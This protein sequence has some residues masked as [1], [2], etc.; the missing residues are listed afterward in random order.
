MQIAAIIRY[1]SFP[2]SQVGETKVGRNAKS[3]RH[4]MINLR[5]HPRYHAPSI[6][7]YVSV[8][9]VYTIDRDITLCVRAVGSSTSEEYNKGLNSF[10]RGNPVDVVIRIPLLSRNLVSVGIY[11]TSPALT[12]PYQERIQ[13]E[14]GESPTALRICQKH[15]ESMTERVN[16]PE[17]PS[18]EQQ[19]E[20]NCQYSSYKCY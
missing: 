12:E 8:S 6:R 7:K 2:F 3:R 13:G 19:L 20:L 10:L 18:F 5:F 17:P 16:I 9:P 11:K 15:S 4:F 14:Q 1:G